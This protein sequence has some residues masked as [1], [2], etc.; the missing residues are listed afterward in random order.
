MAELLVVYGDASP[1]YLDWLSQCLNTGGT[2]F[3]LI[4]ADVLI[5]APATDFSR[6]MFACELNEVGRDSKIDALL[7]HLKRYF[8][9]EDRRET[10]YTGFVVR[11]KTDLYTKSYGRWL[12]TTLSALGANVIGKPLVEILPDYANFRTWQRSTGYSV[13]VIACQQL[14][15]LAERISSAEHVRLYRPKFLVLHACK[16]GTSNTLALWRMVETAMKSQ[17]ASFDL[18]EIR[19]ARGSILDCIG[20]PYEVC[21]QS[22]KQLD[23]VMGGQFVEE[24]MPALDWA[25]VVVWLCPNYNDSMSADLMAVINRMSGFYRTRVLSGKRVYSIIVSGNSGSD[26]VAHQLV[27]ALTLNKGFGLP[28]Y[29]AMNEIAN[30]ANSIQQLAGIKDRAQAF[31][32]RIIVN[33]C[34]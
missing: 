29:F 7:I 32:R 33:T 30:E 9:L 26:S 18:R 22:A 15:A 1:S 17:G 2:P 3:E 23:C 20:C 24:V 12:S 8:P 34:E 4:S 11:S 28:P 25:D 31:A 14:V 19:I 10:F 5:H 16:E 27:G 13:D 21:I 6:L